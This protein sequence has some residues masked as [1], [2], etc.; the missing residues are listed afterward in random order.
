MDYFFISDP[1]FGHNLAFSQR[2]FDTIEEMDQVIIDNVRNTVK[3]ND[4]VFWLGDMFF[5][6]SERR[7]EIAGQLTAK[8]R[9]IVILGNHDR[10]RI[11]YG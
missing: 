4:I 11:S 3:S 10:G 8:G 6:K 5:A 1:H 9:H 7:F 2:P